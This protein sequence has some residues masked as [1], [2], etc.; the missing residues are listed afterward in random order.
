MNIQDIETK[1]DTP[2]KLAFA[3]GKPTN[4]FLFADELNSI[5]DAVKKNKII[6]F[7]EFIVYRRNIPPVIIKGGEL[8]LPQANPQNI[9]IGDYVKGIVEN[10][11]IEAL[12]IGGDLTQQ[13][14]FNIYNQTEF[15]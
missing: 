12:Y 1:V 5:V 13:T 2:E 9:Q 3:L 11:Y 10:I 4:E 15:E 14:S 6:E 7:G 8:V